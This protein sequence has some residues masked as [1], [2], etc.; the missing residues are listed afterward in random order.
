MRKEPFV[1]MVE[2]ERVEV[3]ML[4]VFHAHYGEPPLVQ[5]L[6]VSKGQGE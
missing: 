2:G 6:S 5:A 3:M 4:L 1:H